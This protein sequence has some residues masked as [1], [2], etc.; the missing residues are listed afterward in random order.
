MK[1]KT[2][3]IQLYK[4]EYNDMYY[5]KNKDKIKAYHIDYYQKNKE[6]ILE[7]QKKYYETHKEQIALRYKNKPNKN[8]GAS[9]QEKANKPKK[10]TKQLFLMKPNIP[11]N[12]NPF[13]NC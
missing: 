7:Y 3:D 1:V 13:M 10:K 8:Y 6:R 11:V 9:P 4:Q 12:P 2:A 5:E